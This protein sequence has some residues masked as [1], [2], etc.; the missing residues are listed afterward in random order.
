MAAG[1]RKHLQL[2]IDRSF[3]GIRVFSS[4]ES[5]LL[6]LGYRDYSTVEGEGY[7]SKDREENVIGKAGIILACPFSVRAD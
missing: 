4:L 1:S 7:E 6:K 3:S 2:Y 5:Y